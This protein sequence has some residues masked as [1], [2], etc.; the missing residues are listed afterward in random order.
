MLLTINV[1]LLAPVTTND[2][3]LTEWSILLRERLMKNSL[4]R[5]A[6]LTC[7]LKPINN[8]LDLINENE[9]EKADL[10]ISMKLS[11]TV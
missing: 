1:I 2:E 10:L 6:A 5:A 11:L 7:T 3:T 4:P 9:M 8:A